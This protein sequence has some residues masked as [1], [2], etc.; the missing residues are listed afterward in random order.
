MEILVWK[1]FIIK[2]KTLIALQRRNKRDKMHLKN[3]GPFLL[4]SLI[5]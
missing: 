5:H 1:Y 4:L 2:E 3:E